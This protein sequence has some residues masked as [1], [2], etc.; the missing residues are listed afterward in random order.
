[1][2]MAW[3]NTTY[4]IR[5]ILGIFGGVLLLSGCGPA[6]EEPPV[7]PGPVT[8]AYRSYTSTHPNCRDRDPDNGCV[9][10]NYLWPEFRQ[11]REP[12]SDS[13]KSEIGSFLFERDTTGFGAAH[14]DSLS[15]LWFTMYDSVQARAGPYGLAWEERKNVSVLYQTPEYISLEF[16]VYQFTGGAHPLTERYYRSYDKR[17]GKRL[18]AGDLFAGRHS[19]DVLLQAESRFRKARNI[20]LE[21]EPADSG[22]HFGDGEFMLPDNIALVWD[23]LLV[24]YNPYEIAPYYRGP[25]RLLLPYDNIDSLLRPRFRRPA[26][27]T[28]AD[29]R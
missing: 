26:P 28:P 3:A 16:Y 23:G 9:E 7:K 12:L 11:V 8:Y 14:F 4:P 27:G 19:G 15:S 17:N 21:A 24:W 20:P 25:T 2:G 1:M 5:G 22:Y 18:L 13:L 10:L 6:G 29:D